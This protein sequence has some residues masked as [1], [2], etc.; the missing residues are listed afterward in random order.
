MPGGVGPDDLHLF[1]T[2]LLQAASDSL[3][4]IPTLLPGEGLTGAP[5]RQFISPGPPVWDCCEMLV[6][7]VE[8]LPIGFTRPTSPIGASGMKQAYGAWILQAVLTV[9]VGR[10]VPEGTTSV[11]GKYTPPSPAALTAAARQIDADGWALQNGIANRKYQ[12]ILSEVCSAMVW[13]T[14]SSVD[15]MGGCGGWTATFRANIDGYG[16]SDPIPT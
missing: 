3:D 12:G 15:P 16:A 5:A 4:E 10:C 6:V 14:F 7:H 8:S 2:D 11:K 1:A 9:T 13:E